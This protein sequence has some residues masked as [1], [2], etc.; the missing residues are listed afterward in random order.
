MVQLMALMLCLLSQT[1][2]QSDHA[3][4]LDK[5]ILQVLSNMPL[6]TSSCVRLACAVAGPACNQL[7]TVVGYPA[8]PTTAHYAGL[9]MLWGRR[10]IGIDHVF[11][12]DNNEDGAAQA[13]QLQDFIDDGFL[14]LSQVDGEKKQMQVYEHCLGIV[15]GRYSWMAAFDIDEFIVVTDPAA[16]NAVSSVKAVLQEFRFRP[17]TPA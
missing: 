4:R 1:W 15:A 11:L 12:H 5:A 8:A 13:V 9:T 6:Q 7:V 3:G 2:G 17:G 16:K 14:T 10:Y